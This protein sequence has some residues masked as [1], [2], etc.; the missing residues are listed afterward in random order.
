M[1]LARLRVCTGPSKHS[2]LADV[3]AY[4]GLEFAVAYTLAKW[5][6]LEPN[7]IDFSQGFS[8]KLVECF[9]KLF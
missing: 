3:R 8:Q 9:N 1:A 2:L 5:K 7:E 6:K 4:P